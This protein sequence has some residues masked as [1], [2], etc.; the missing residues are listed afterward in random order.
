MLRNHALRDSQVVLAREATLTELARLGRERGIPIVALKSSAPSIRLPSLD[1]D[2]LVPE[3]RLTEVTE[4]LRGRDFQGTHGYLE[5]PE[6][7]QLHLPGRARPGEMMV[8]VHRQLG[9]GEPVDTALWRTLRPLPA[10]PGCFRLPAE[11]QAWHLLWHSVVMHPHRRG[12]L[13]DLLLIG[14]ALGDLEPGARQ[15]LGERIRAPVE[16][17]PLGRALRMAEE[18]RGGVTPEDEFRSVAAAQYRWRTTRALALLPARPAKSLEAQW[19]PLADGDPIAPLWER[20]V[21][22]EGARSVRPWLHAIE[23]AAP[24]ATRAVRMIVRASVFTLT[25]PL[26]LGLSRAARADGRVSGSS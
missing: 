26:A 8:E 22:A 4:Y 9:D 7:H 17:G 19:F 3:E 10:H 13:G 5:D 16:A 15:A 20:W 14:E 12:Q 1:L 18:L 23:T 24:G 2:V 11:R 25:L 21:T 6:L